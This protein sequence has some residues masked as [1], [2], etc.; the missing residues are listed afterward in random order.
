MISLEKE[1]LKWNAK[2]APVKKRI[3]R[4]PVLVNRFAGGVPLCTDLNFDFK[5]KNLLLCKIRM[6]TR[7]IIPRTNCMFRFLGS[8]PVLTKE[9][10]LLIAFLSI[11]LNHLQMNQ[12]MLS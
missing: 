6:S 11:K 10:R 1:I 9:L 3:A 7:T 5:E 2:I 4:K 8:Y 12:Q